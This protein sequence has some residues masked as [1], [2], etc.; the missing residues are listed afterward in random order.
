MRGSDGAASATSCRYFTGYKPCGRNDVCHDECPKREPVTSHL[1][2]IHLE[3]LG[4]VLR[5]T[6]ILP[7]LKRK[8]SGSHITWVTKAPADQLLANNPFI[9]R[10]LTISNDDLLKLKALEFDF[11]FVID[12]S[13][14]AMGV[15]A[16]TQADY[17]FGFA[18]DARTGAIVP[19]TESALELW[20]I[21]LNDQKKFFENK[22]PETQL[23]TESLELDWKR[24][25]Y[26]FFF[27]NEELSLIQARKKQWRGGAEA[28]LGIN[29][30]CS[31]VI[32]YKKLTVQYHRKL[33][34]EIQKKY[35][36]RISIVLLG[37]REDTERN[38]EIAWGF[39]NIIQSP[40]A[41]GLRDGAVSVA[42]CDVVIT[43]D[44]LGMHMAIAFRKWV[45]AWF[46]PTCAHEIDLYDRGVKIVSAATCSPCWKRSCQKS[47]MCYDQ[48]EVSAFMDAVEKG[49]NWHKDTSSYRQPSLEISS[50]QSL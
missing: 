11:A 48:I 50:S 32:P 26:Q 47:P 49:L 42:A 27:T 18:C 34:E 25:P 28:I 44:S 1:L 19:A 20:E 8:F 17:I 5:A 23:I 33:V 35:G 13:L 39:Q 14:T 46:G 21:G 38:Q 22:K 6:S 37:G 7:A 43:G 3:A 40:T 15:L 41:A 2:V 29:T 16:H 10:V 45:A 36:K 24:D 9:D 12:K 4:A 31:H 30:G